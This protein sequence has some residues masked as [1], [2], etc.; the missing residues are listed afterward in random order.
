MQVPMPD[1]HARS[2]ILS[3]K[4]RQLNADLRSH[5]PPPSHQCSNVSG[6]SSS[7]GGAAPAPVT[8][9]VPSGW[10]DGANAK[11]RFQAGH[12]VT[13]ELVKKLSASGMYGE[14]RLLQ[15]CW[16]SG[17]CAGS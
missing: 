7:S 4:L 5:P 16:A 3:K 10:L 11:G 6:G 1:T 14:V 13:E 17:V 15:A 9:E 12:S 2:C 8:L